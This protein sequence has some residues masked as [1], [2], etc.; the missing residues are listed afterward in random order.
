M[1]S[2]KTLEKVNQYKRY[3]NYNK[4]GIIVS[5]KEDAPKEVKEFYE[6]EILPEVSITD[7][8]VFITFK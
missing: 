3:F 2:N 4:T 6:N 1:L 5:V 8:G 7:D